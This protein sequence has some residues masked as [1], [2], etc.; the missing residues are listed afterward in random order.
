MIGCGTVQISK[1]GG[2]GLGGGGAQFNFNG[3]S[4]GMPPKKYIHSEIEPK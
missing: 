3:R 4:G 1:W 2:G